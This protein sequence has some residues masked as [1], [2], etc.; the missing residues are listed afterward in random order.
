MTSVA[1]I[2]RH[3]DVEVME[4]MDSMALM[5]TWE[6]IEIHPFAFL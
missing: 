2:C 1:E 4:R 5:L 3:N 6:A